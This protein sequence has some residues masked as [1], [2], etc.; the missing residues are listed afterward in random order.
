MKKITFNL[1]ATILVVALHTH[2]LGAQNCAIA[3]AQA[4]LDINNVNARIL[5]GG[6]LWWNPV[7]AI[8][9]YEVPA[10][11][12][13]NAI[14]AGALW[15]G[16]ID[17]FGQLRVAAQTYRQTGNDF[18]PGVLNNNGTVTAQTCNNFDHIWK[19][20]GSDINNFLSAFIAAGGSSMAASAVPTAL[21]NWPARN[22][23]HFSS[24]TLPADKDLAPFYD[25]N[26]DGNYDPTR[27]DYPVI[28][29][30]NPAYADQMTWCVFN[31]NGSTHTE[32]GGMPLQMEIGL[33]AYAFAEPGNETINNATFYRY[34]LRNYNA[35]RIDNLLVGLFV[36]PDMGDGLDDYVGCIPSQNLG[37]VYNGD[38]NDGVY[39]SPPPIIGIQFIDPLNDENG[40][41]VNMNSFMSYNNDF[42]PTGNPTNYD[43][44][45]GRLKA[46]WLDGSHVTYGGNGYGGTTPTNFMFDG[47]PANNTQWSECSGGNY[48]NDRR[49]IMAM[50]SISME[51]FAKKSFTVGVYYIANAGGCP[52]TSITGLQTAAIIAEGYHDIL[53]AQATSTQS[54][55]EN[56]K[57]AISIYPNP[58]SSHCLIKTAPNTQSISIYD[59]MGKIVAGPISPDGDQ[60]LIKTNNWLQGSYIVKTIGKNGQVN[61]QKILKY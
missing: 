10:G 11:S 20:E 39:G 7:A 32:T 27:G 36:D 57:T 44:Y 43:D 13:K 47:N 45:Y 26:S 17:T 52:N 56:G 58:I 23:P 34:T 1:F 24:F 29:S 33:L 38:N 16:G 37:Y 21:L 4:N 3:S 49:M 8:P 50:N 25:Y 30:G 55:T 54:P 48:P 60:T 35:T 53:N 2:F 28:E 9:Q 14:F 40:N 22:N 42:T 31:D 15:M 19:I 5:N 59:L 61:A 41:D 51:R 12:G 6:D 46:Q 18:F